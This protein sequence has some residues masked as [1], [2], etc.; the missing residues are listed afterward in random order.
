VHPPITGGTGESDCVAYSATSVTFIAAYHRVSNWIYMAQHEVEAWVE[1]Q[2][3]TQLPSSAA[4]FAAALASSASRSAPSTPCSSSAS[5]ST[6]PVDTQGQG[7]EPGLGSLFTGGGSAS[8]VFPGPVEHTAVEACAPWP[9][10]DAVDGPR[11]H[12][13][14]GTQLSGRTARS[15]PVSEKSNN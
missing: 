9:P 15:S 12:D 10:S 2:A 3:R 6:S 8:S 13:F 14:A 5:P 1:R 11:A 4:R 7:L